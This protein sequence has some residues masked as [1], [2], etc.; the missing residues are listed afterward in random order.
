MCVLIAGKAVTSN[1]IRDRLVKEAENNVS[2]RVK[3]V[4]GSDEFEVTQP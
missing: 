3:P 4:E 2:I 1:Q